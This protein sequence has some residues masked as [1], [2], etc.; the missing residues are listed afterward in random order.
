[1]WGWV[2]YQ[3]LK[4]FPFRLDL[5][6]SVSM[7]RIASQNAASISRWRAWAR[8]IPGTWGIFKKGMTFRIHFRKAWIGEELD[9]RVTVCD[10]ESI[11]SYVRFN[12]G[13]RASALRDAVP[14]AAAIRR[15]WSS[16]IRVSRIKIPSQ[17]R[18]VTSSKFLKKFCL[19]LTLQGP[20]S[21]LAFASPH[22]LWHYQ[23]SG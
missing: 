14:A 18:T 5:W 19:T 7:S 17:A 22:R 16:A 15:F 8:G 2:L 10:G 13:W 1:M 11:W 21:R 3:G 9:T 23:A 12:E 6:S 4:K 20:S